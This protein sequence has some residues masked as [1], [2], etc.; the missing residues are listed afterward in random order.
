MAG[1]ALGLTLGRAT[2]IVLLPQAF[3]IVLPP[4][5]SE[6]MN[7]IKN[8]SVALTIGL[9]ELTGRARAMQEFSFKVFEAFAAATVIYLLTNLVVVFAHARAGEKGARAGLIS[10]SPPPGGT[11][12]WIPASTS[13]SSSAPGSTCSGRHDVHADADRPRDGRRHLLRHAAGDDAAV[14]IPRARARRGGY[15]N[16][17][18]SLPLVLVIFW[19]FFLVPYI[20][21]WIIGAKDPVK[22]GSFCPA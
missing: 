3:R 4:L 14:E 8:S 20:G 16:L 17:M 9:L 22:V 13:T 15:V 11:E 12:A 6:F 5:T 21:A 10:A 19:F 18:R 1:T 7:V 2:A